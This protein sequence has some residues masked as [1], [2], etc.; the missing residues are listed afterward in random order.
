MTAFAYN[1]RQVVAGYTFP[2]NIPVTMSVGFATAGRISDRSL[3]HGQ[4]LASLINKASLASTLAKKDNTGLKTL[5]QAT[6]SES[7]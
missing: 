4:L 3:P 7:A 5:E 6:D 2:D 1:L